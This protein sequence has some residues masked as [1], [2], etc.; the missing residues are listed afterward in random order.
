MKPEDRYDSLFIIYG[1]RYH[2]PW[3][4]LKAQVKQESAFD[5][6][7]VNPKTGATGLAQFM[8]R[9]WEEWRDAAPGIQNIIDAFK[10]LD[11]RDPEDAIKAQAA[12]MDWLIAN[13]GGG[14]KALAAYNWGIGNIW[15]C[16]KEFGDNW[17]DHLPEE[18]RDYVA[19]IMAYYEDYQA[20]G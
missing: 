3:K 17:R 10:L 14:E 16:V 15:K 18:T 5:P 9:T 12:Y 1:D 13:T 4:F 11:P 8:P 7:A 2:V 19:K 6:D 20:K